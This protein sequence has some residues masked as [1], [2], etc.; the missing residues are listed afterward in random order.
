MMKYIHEVSLSGA[1][2]R[3]AFQFAFVRELLAAGYE[4]G[5]FSGVSAGAVNAYLLSIED[6]ELGKRVW[7]EE[8]PALFTRRDKIEAAARIILSKPSAFS[9]AVA[10]R[11]VDRHVELWKVKRNFAVW[12]VDYAGELHGVSTREITDTEQLRN[13]IRASF[14]IPGIFP[15][16]E[17][18]YTKH[19][20]FTELMDAGVRAMIPPSYFAA[21]T[22]LVVT[23][24]T[25][26]D[27]FFPAASG[28]VLQSLLRAYDMMSAEISRNDLE[29]RDY[30]SPIAAL[31]GAFDFRAESIADSYRIGVETAK[32]W[33]K[34]QGNGQG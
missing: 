24:K 31:P 14:A 8:I 10:E 28:G 4:I 33:L 32:V 3:G 21:V 29:G 19:R 9:Q 6:E 34:G 18:A 20:D 30:V 17:Y 12:F 5:H 27:S 1:G 13:F 22:R 26:L 25:D 11:L 7:L 2:A 23:V 15:S 16:V